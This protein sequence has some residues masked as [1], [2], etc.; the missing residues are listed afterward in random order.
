[1]VMESFITVNFRYKK[2]TMRAAFIGVFLLIIFSLFLPAQDRKEYEFEVISFKEGLSQNTVT[3]IIQDRDGFMWMGTQHGLHKYNGY[4]F[5]IYKKEPKNENSLSDNNVEIMVE[6]RSGTLWV[7]TSG[8]GLNRIDRETMGFKH[9]RHDPANPNSLTDNFVTSIIQDRDGSLWIGTSNGLNRL[10]PETGHISHF[11]HQTDDADSLNDNSILALHE[12]RN[13]DIWIGTAE[14]GLDRLDKQHMRFHHHTHHPADPFSLSFNRVRAIAQDPRGFLWIGTEGGGLNRLDPGENETKFIHYR[15]SPSDPRSPGSD[16]I[17]ALLVDHKGTLWVGTGEGGVNVFDAETG[18][19]QVY[20]RNPKRTTGLSDNTVLSIYEDRTGVIWLGTAVGGINKISAWKRKFTHV[21]EDPFNRNSLNNNMVWAICEDERGY[22]WIGTDGG[23]LNRLD[24]KNGEYKF[25]KHEPGNPGSL[26]SDIVRS[27]LEDHGGNLWIGTLDKG[28]DLFDRQREIFIHYP[29]APDNINSLG[30]NDVLALFEDVSGRLWLGLNGAGL[31]LLKKNNGGS[32]GSVDFMHFKADPANPDSLSN[33]FVTAIY[34]D[35]KGNLWVGTYEVLNKWEKEHNRGLKP[36]FKHYHHDPE[37]PQSISDNGIGA[38]YRDSTGRLWIGT[39]MGLNRWLPESGTFRRYSLKEGLPGETVYG[40][41]EDDSHLL[42]IS[43][44]KGLSRFNPETGKFRNYDFQDGL[45]SNEFNSGACFKNKKGEMFFGGIDGMNVFNPAGI[46]DNPFVPPVV[47]TDLKVFNESRRF[48]Y[49]KE[50]SYMDTISITYKENFI[51]LEFAALDYNNP[52]KN[53]YAYQL[54]GFDREWRNCAQGVR[55]VT[56]SNLSGGNYVLKIKGTNNDGI[57]NEEGTAV[58]IVVI[59]PFYQSGWFRGLVLLSLMVCGIGFYYIKMYTLKKQRQKLE[60]LVNERTRELVKAKDKAEVAVRARTEFLAHMSHEIR[61]PMHGIIGMTDLTLETHLG[62]EQRDN[63]KVVKASANDLLDIINDILD[64]SLVESGRLKLE[65][66]DF[67]LYG[68]ISGIIKLLAASAHKKNLQL[69]YFIQPE[70]PAY[71]NGD[72][73]R[74][75]QVLVNLLGNAIKFTKK[76]EIILGVRIGENTD[77]RREPGENRLRLTFSVSDTGIGAAKEKQELIFEPFVQADNSPTRPYGGSGLGLSIS[78]GLVELMEGK[79]RVKS[80]TNYRHPGSGTAAQ[81]GQQEESNPNFYTASSPQGGKG[82]TF[83]FTIPLKAAYKEVEKDKPPDTGQLKGLPV[84]V[85]DN[86]HTAVKILEKHLSCRDMNPL[87]VENAGEALKILHR[88]GERANPP[89]KL[90]IIDADLCGKDGFALVKE[91]KAHEQFAGIKI[92]ILVRSDQIVDA[93]QGRQ[94]GIAGYLSKPIEPFELL[95]TILRVMGIEDTAAGEPESITGH[96]LFE[97]GRKINFLVAEDN[98][99]NQ[100]LI[101]KMLDTLGFTVTITEN[102]KETLAKLKSQRFDVI[103][104]DIQM[105]E[106]DG[107]ETTREIRRLE[108]ESM[109]LSNA[110]ETFAH[111]PIIA[112]TA[113]AMKGDREKFLGAGMDAYVSKPLKKP[114][115]IAAIKSV[116]PIIEQNN[117]DSQ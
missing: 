75:R 89:F 115:L 27:I 85:V 69:N 59:P 74:L 109:K 17:F 81:Q 65:S 9:Y 33:N 72:P 32:V 108:A 26:G 42:W 1:M 100:K 4:D 43:S 31:A 76:G 53:H 3:S 88:T 22:L 95:Q 20:R 29:H 23:G 112:L 45:Q 102:G 101:K 30:H 78:S 61:T 34:E 52:H 55:S 104:M 39:D 47:I 64:F 36:F 84:L 13:G 46:V 114:D 38:I 113:H 6:D 93:K 41:L 25:Y 40:I 49:E 82:A 96:A 83:Y 80:P 91:I 48:F 97:E 8:G 5:I 54:K 86:H 24:R 98:K 79:I 116:C 62:E 50:I 107:L 56:Y 71:L 99:I 60:E 68:T 87:W 92:I 10:D 7:G 106:M 110:P 77:D 103:L 19:F 111:I 44:N 28:L 66:M 18:K 12:D 37:D 58:K 51:T 73:G 67:N 70:I 90:A 16:Y 15:H 11:K 57:G 21:K 63:L 35:G 2:S 117:V 105:P 94:L 14:G